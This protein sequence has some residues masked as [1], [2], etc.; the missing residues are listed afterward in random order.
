MSS[1][2]TTVSTEA[3]EE[4]SYSIVDA[5]E[6]G[7]FAI[8]S[9]TGQV[10]VTGLLDYEAIDL[11]TL[12]VGAEAGGSLLDTTT[13]AITITD[14]FES[15]ILVDNPASLISQ[16]VTLT[17]STDDAGNSSVSYQWWRLVDSEWIDESITDPVRSISANS[18]ETRVYRVVATV[19]GLG[20]ATSSSVL[21]RWSPLAVDIDVAPELPLTGDVVTLRAFTYI[22]SGFGRPRYGQPATPFPPGFTP[23][24]TGV[25]TA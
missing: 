12:T 22:P 16:S 17:A 6:D 18:E 19:D 13:V 20:Q 14:V 2:P 15:N 21:I 5:N 3:A 8:D 7:H 9:A 4:M 25:L 24:S 11:Y 1:A 10:T 23:P